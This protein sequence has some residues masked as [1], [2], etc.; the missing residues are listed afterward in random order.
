MFENLRHLAHAPSVQ[1]HEVP[2]DSKVPRWATGGGGLLEAEREW[3][4]REGE[5]EEIR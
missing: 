1:L 2:P 5:G 4:K 3:A